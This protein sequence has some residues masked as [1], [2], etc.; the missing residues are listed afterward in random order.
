M[1]IYRVQ[2]YPDTEEWYNEYL[3]TVAEGQ[4]ELNNRTKAEVP[5]RLDKME[6]VGVTGDR[7]GMCDFLNTLHGNHMVQEPSLFLERNY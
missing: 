7:E 1:I 2:G 4:R 6:I 3:P 5:A